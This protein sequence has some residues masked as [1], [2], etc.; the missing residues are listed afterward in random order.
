MSLSRAAGSGSSGKAVTHCVTGMVNTPKG[1]TQGGGSP[2]KIKREVNW[3]PCLACNMGGA[4]DLSVVTHP[5][6]SCSIWNSLS[7]K[8]KESKV[9]CLKCPF[10]NDHNTA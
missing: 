6:E 2:A 3:K 5:V 9:R 10:R 4:T 7:Q 1:G 8:D